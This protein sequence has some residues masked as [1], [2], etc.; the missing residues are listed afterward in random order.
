V[1][2]FHRPA[3][4]RAG[5]LFDTGPIRRDLWRL[6]VIFLAD[7]QFAII[8]EQEFFA[9]GHEQLLLALSSEFADDEISRILL[10]SAI[11]LRVIDDREGGVLERFADCG[12][13]QADVEAERVEP[14]SLR[15]ACN[16]IVHAEQVNSDVE[17]LD[18]GPVDR[19]GM[20]P[21]FINPLLYLYG[22]H[23]RM[24]WRCV[25]DVISFVR[26]AAAVLSWH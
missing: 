17:R 13:L 5:H 4:F 22:S 11:A 26:S 9:D 24:R 2:E 20:S 19:P 3:H 12:E 25:L 15:E 16:K 8:T 23:N 14:L 10:S 1:A 6:L 21:T 7:R 18:G